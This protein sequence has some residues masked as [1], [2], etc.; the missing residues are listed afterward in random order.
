[1]L[2]PKEHD[3]VSFETTLAPFDLSS[4]VS[5]L[6]AYPPKREA[7]T[8]SKFA[9]I[10]RAGVRNYKSQDALLPQPNTG[11]LAGETTN[12]RMQCAASA[13]VRGSENAIPAQ[14]GP[15]SALHAGNRETW[16]R[17]G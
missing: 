12:P 8:S 5:G 6:R 16:Y 11:G 4:A 2:L 17:I 1:M 7:G 13:H 14:N 9:Q 3:L 10:L 15:R